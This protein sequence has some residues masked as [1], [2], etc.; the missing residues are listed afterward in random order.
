M[1]NGRVIQGK[2]TVKVWRKFFEIDFGSSYCESSEVGS[3]GH[4]NMQPLGRLGKKAC[5]KCQA[6]E[7]M[8]LASKVM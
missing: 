2:I 6:L 7:N 3:K 1:R 8:Q 5:H 4:E